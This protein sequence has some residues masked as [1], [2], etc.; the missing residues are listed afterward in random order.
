LWDENSDYEAVLPPKAE[1]EIKRANRYSSITTNHHGKESRR[2][3][4]V[5]H[6]VPL[7]SAHIPASADAEK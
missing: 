1:A 2:H 7:L 5:G 3:I 6:S 4:I